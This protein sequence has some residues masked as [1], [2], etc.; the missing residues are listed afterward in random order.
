MEQI[1]ALAGGPCIYI[2]R[3]MKTSHRGLG[4][5]EEEWKANLERRSK[6]LMRMAFWNQSG[7]SS[8][9]Y[10]NAFVERSWKRRRL[11]LVCDLRFRRQS[12]LDREQIHPPHEYL[13]AVVVRTCRP[14]DG[15]ASRATGGPVARLLLA[16]DRYCLELPPM[17]PP[18]S[19]TLYRHHERSL[20]FN[21]A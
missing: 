5:T 4:I 16:S 15:Y 12:Y 3:D 13:I 17:W 2:G 20:L 11:G 7:R 19:G 10:L 14:T 9:S 1:C 21:A 6:R 8:W 18:G